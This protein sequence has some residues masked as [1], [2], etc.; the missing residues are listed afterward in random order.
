[1]DEQVV[2]G[3]DQARLEQLLATAPRHA[4][5]G[6]SVADAARFS[7]QAVGAYVGQVR[8]SSAAERTGLRLGDII[9]QIGGR[10][11]RSAAELEQVMA[12]LA[13]GARLAV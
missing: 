12:G 7:P 3:F 13:P 8:S 2:V 9:V 4:A 10:P 5:L 11:V 6:A 1:M